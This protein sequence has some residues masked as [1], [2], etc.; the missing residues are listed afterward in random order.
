MTYPTNNSI[1]GPAAA[2]LLCLCLRKGEGTPR[3]LCVRACFKCC[4]K[5]EEGA[6][7]LHRDAN[8]WWAVGMPSVPLRLSRSPWDSAFFCAHTALHE[9]GIC[10]EW[11]SRANPSG[12]ARAALIT[13]CVPQLLLDELMVRGFGLAGCWSVAVAFQAVRLTVNGTRLLLPS[14]VLS[15]VEPL[16]DQLEELEA[17]GRQRP[18]WELSV[19]T[20]K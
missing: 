19:S 15:R 1:H 5:Q 7:M 11:W 4:G 13:A 17:Q 14:S 6:D 8:S 10:E 20:P 12:H 3:P 16:S 18:G 9:L 2:R